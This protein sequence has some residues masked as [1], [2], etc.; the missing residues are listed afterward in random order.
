MEL[1]T[2]CQFGDTVPLNNSARRVMFLQNFVKFICK[3]K[4]IC[5][6]IPEAALYFLKLFVKYASSI[7]EVLLTVGTNQYY[8][9][10]LYNLKDLNVFISIKT[11]CKPPNILIEPGR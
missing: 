5:C 3:S 9:N 2:L 7:S 10:L 4:T 6:H 8:F 1:V 11:N